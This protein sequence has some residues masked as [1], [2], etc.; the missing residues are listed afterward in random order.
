MLSKTEIRL[1]DLLPPIIPN[2]DHD[3]IQCQSRVVPISSDV[4]YEALSYVWG[5]GLETTILEMDGNKIVI[6]RTLEA[7]LRRVRL[8][9]AK[10]TIWVDQL[11]ID[12]EDLQEKAN[13]VP[14]MGE[15]YSKT[16]QCLIW[17]GEIRPDISLADASAALDIIRF[18]STC[19]QDGASNAEIPRCFASEQTLK[20]PMR[21]WAS[22][23]LKEN[24]WWH[25][26]WTLQEVILP[27]KAC[28]L[29]GPLSIPWDVIVTA[30]SAG[31]A[32]IPNVS[33]PYLHIMNNLFTQTNG[34]T[35]AKTSTPSPLDTA[36]RWS[37]R[38][39]TNPLDKVY[40]LLGLFPSGTLPRSQRCDYR[41][42]M[43]SVCA[44]FT[45]DL[46]EHHQS[47]HP[48]ALRNLANLPESTPGIPT[49]AL[50]MA[51]TERQY[52]VQVCGDDFPW[53]LMHNYYWYSAS[54][55]SEIDWEQFRFDSEDNTLTLTGYKLDEIAF[56]GPRPQSDNP[57]SPEI[58]CAGV[59]R[60]IQR[61][62]EDG[63]K[64]Y[65]GRVWP[66]DSSGHKS[67]PESFWRGLLGNLTIGDELIPED[68]ASP[69]DI[70]L[71]EEFVHTGIK[72]ASCK[73]V[74]ATMCHRTMF[75]THTGFL[76]F[77][78]AHLSVGDEVWIL[79]GGSVPFVLRRTIDRSMPDRRLF[80]GPSYVD[81]I[82][83]GELALDA[84]Q[85]DP[86][87]LV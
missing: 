85:F 31:F 58:S 11:S 34:L 36:F 19:E 8:A 44:M 23:C 3:T 48:I 33:R 14:S 24:P 75:I 32:P 25:R 12:Q 61:W 13:Q 59:V 67:W 74:F 49:W 39:A 72:N 15:I 50:D 80:I 81:G 35:F 84:E 51:V 62:F 54:G 16:R 42:S 73:G 71:V 43:A 65:D 26:I 69:E 18:M 38:R 55:D 77:G 46:I 47:L 52:T 63:S 78:P 70:A 29:W 1:L 86:I 9:D 56:A 2:S 82:M 21:A 30:G 17:M 28:V 22:M 66:E 76:G 4:D 7:A 41:A 27:S 6:T 64:F 45:A 10:R 53:Y 37:F 5:N 40:G 83:K 87:S 20:G 60:Q 57:D 79:Q 68:W